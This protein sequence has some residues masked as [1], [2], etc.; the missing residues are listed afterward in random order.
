MAS[1]NKE[2]FVEAYKESTLSESRSIIVDTKTGVHY[3]WMKGTMGAG[4]TPLLDENGK[5][6]ITKDDI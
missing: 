6:I 4:I 5:I 2:R 3:F 1:K